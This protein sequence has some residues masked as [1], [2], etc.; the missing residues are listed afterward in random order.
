MDDY[1]KQSDDGVKELNIETEEYYVEKEKED[2]LHEVEEER[3]PKKTIYDHIRFAMIIISFVIYLFS[4]FV[5]YGFALMIFSVLLFTIAT[6]FM[7]AIKKFITE[8][9][10][11]SLLFRAS[12]FLRIILFLFF[13]LS[14]SMIFLTTN[15]DLYYSYW[16]AVISFLAIATIEYIESSI[17]DFRSRKNWSWFAR[18][19]RTLLDVFFLIVFINMI[20]MMVRLSLPGEGDQLVVN[21]LKSP[22]EVEVTRYGYND[23]NSQEAISRNTVSINDITFL[24]QLTSE[25]GFRNYEPMDIISELNYIK[26]EKTADVYYKLNLHYDVYENSNIFDSYLTTITFIDNVLVLRNEKR[27]SNIWLFQN[28]VNDY[29]YLDLSEDTINKLNSF[30]NTLGD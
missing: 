1:S 7:G 20:S 27:R 9:D 15:Y 10:D 25:L 30:I 13:F 23:L 18:L 22:K 11:C 24:K 12:F 8:G 16:I 6:F 19:L 28:T 3:K 4:D 29:Y 26:L 14:L 17:W 5:K 2:S 21:Q